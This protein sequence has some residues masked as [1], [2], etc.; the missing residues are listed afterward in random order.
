[1]PESTIL[2]SEPEWLQ[3][4]ARSW[5]EGATAEPRVPVGLEVPRG[6]GAGERM[7]AWRGRHRLRAARA[8]AYFLSSRAPERGLPVAP[9]SAV[10]GFL[11]ELLGHRR[12]KVALLLLAN[13]AAAVTGLVVPRILGSLVDRA[14]G[15]DTVLAGLNALAIAVA[16]VV[17]LQSLLTFG[18]RF[19]SAVVGQDVLASARESVVRTVLALPLGRVES[20]SSGDLVTRVTRDVSAMSNSVQHALPQAV[21]AGATSVLTIVAL[22][23]NSPLLAVPSLIALVL[24]S[25]PVR[26]Y[27]RHAPKGYITEG[28]TYSTINTTFTETVEGARTIEALGL[29]RHRISA[30]DDDVAESSQAE[31]YTM[32]LRNLM[33]GWIDLAYNTPLVAVVLVGTYGYQQGWVSLGE[34]TT[35]TLYVQALV[36]PVDRLIANVDRL[37]VGIASTTRLLGIRQVPQDREP[38]DA[39]PDGVDLLARD[40]RFAYR[41]GHD[42]L[43]G[44][45]LRLRPRERLAVVGPSGSGKSTLGRLLAGI[46]RPRTGSVTVGEVELTELPLD[47]LR[48]EVALVTQEHHVFVGTVR[49]NIVL[50]REDS[51]DDV[52]VRALQAVDAWEWVERLENGLDTMLGSGHTSLTPAQAQQIALARLVVADPHTLV[53]DEATSLID[54]RTA[55]DVEGSMSGLLANRSVVAIAHRLHT[56]HDADRIAVVIDGQIVEL[57]SHDELV[58][59]DGEYAALWRAWTS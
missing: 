3:H 33:F 1:M 28:G 9:A 51:A 11:G 13:I 35:A 39:R 29:Q 57:G 40:L 26:R 23:L 43:H 20:A 5:R 55:R 7:R 41:E 59:H 6:V 14:A 25:V 58:A 17:V 32:S 36:E 54:P 52:V 18:A 30:G 53:L 21:I 16:S 49:D 38:G 50:A 37:Q 22:L 2:A 48:T 45:D 47:V 34:I 24:V 46:N 15:G 44:V 42:V 31:R 19:S 12:T 27:L 4:S 10:T 8:E 56:A